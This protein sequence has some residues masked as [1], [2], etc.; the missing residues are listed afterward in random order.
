MRRTSPLYFLESNMKTADEE[1]PK[2]RSWISGTIM[3]YPR[4]G[5]PRKVSFSC[6]WENQLLFQQLEQAQGNSERAR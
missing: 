3:V 5:A 1:S 4:F 6:T 2:L